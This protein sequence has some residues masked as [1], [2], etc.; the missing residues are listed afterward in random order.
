MAGLVRTY[1]LMLSVHNGLYMS[2]YGKDFFANLP[3]GTSPHSVKDDV[4]ESILCY[5]WM[6]I[7]AI[8]FNGLLELYSQLDVPFSKDCLH[9][10]T[11]KKTEELE[12]QLDTI[13]YR[14][15]QQLPPCAADPWDCDM[16]AVDNAEQSIALKTLD[17]TQ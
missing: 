1:V 14:S 7:L 10:P 11:E 4:S 8:F 13:M 9:A 5:G 2:Q 17:A 15:K 6:L 16:E 12:E 3:D